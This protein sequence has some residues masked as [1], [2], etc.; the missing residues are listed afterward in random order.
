MRTGINVAAAYISWF[1]VALLAA[2]GHLL[3]AVLPSLA[4]VALHLGLT[5]NDERGQNLRLMGVALLIGIVV[6]TALVSLGFVRHAA[7]LSFGILPPAFMIG[8]WL[9]F[10][11]MT[12]V[13]LGWLRDRPL[14]TALLAFAASGP[15]YYAGAKLG[16][17]SLGEPV[18]LSCIGIG[19]VWMGALPLLMFA[20][21]RLA[22]PRS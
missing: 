3:A 10:A 16:A 17:I 22:Q 5:P 11:T 13:A 7:G 15:S 14:L 12:N 18:L 8:L 19:L 4:A 21:L 9:A 2:R 6:E 1:A 20:A